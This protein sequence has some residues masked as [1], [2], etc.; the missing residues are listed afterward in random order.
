MRILIALIL[1]IL[2][3]GCVGSTTSTKTA[4]ESIEDKPISTLEAI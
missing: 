3:A 4:T 1:V 2:V